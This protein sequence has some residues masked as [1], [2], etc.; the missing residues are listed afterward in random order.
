MRLTSI[1]RTG[2]AVFVFISARVA[3]MKNPTARPPLS[4]SRIAVR[5]ATADEAHPL[6]TDMINAA[7]RHYIEQFAKDLTADRV[8]KDGKEVMTLMETPDNVFLVAEE[9][10]GDDNSKSL[11]GCVHVCWSGVTDS[12]D[13]D[14][15][16]HFGM[17]SVPKE[18][19][20]RGIGKL[21]V[22]AAEERCRNELRRSNINMEISVVSFFP[23]LFKWYEAQGYRKKRTMP[24]PYPELVRDGCD[25]QLQL[26]AKTIP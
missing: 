3:S 6:L 17:L 21:L 25:F 9:T 5:Q 23:E 20:G 16:A 1:V 15:D 24:F 12:G 7:F 14:V 10:N 26:M 22:S 4:S 8:T 19:S 2:V 13:E 18:C 11:V